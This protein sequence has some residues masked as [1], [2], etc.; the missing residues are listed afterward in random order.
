MRD[1]RFTMD[2]ARVE[3]RV[4]AIELKLET[5]RPATRL[6]VEA[7]VLKLPPRL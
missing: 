6:E 5:L 1:R 3:T 4:E 2:M 7:I